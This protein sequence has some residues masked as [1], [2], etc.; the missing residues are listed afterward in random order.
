MPATE[1]YFDFTVGAPSGTSMTFLQD[2][3]TVIVSSALYY[4]NSNDPDH[5]AFEFSTPTLSTNEFGIGALNT[6]G[7]VDQGFDA[8][9]MYEM[10]TFSFAENVRITSIKLIPLPTR[11]NLTAQD[12]QFVIFNQDLLINQNSR[13]FIDPTDFINSVSVFG[14]YVGFGAVNQLDSFSLAGITVEAIGGLNA[15]ADNYAVKTSDAPVTLDVLANDD[16]GQRITAIDTT[17][18]LGSV[19]LAADGLTLVYSAGSAFDALAKGVQAT[20]TFTYTVLGFDGTS[21]TQTV[22]LT[23]TG[24]PNVIN[25]TAANNLL[26]G[27]ATRD[28][29]TG[30]AGNDTID[31]MGGNDDI[32]GRWGKD[33]LHGND[34]D[35]HVYG[36]GS[37]DYVYGDAGN[38]TVSGGAGNDRLH[39]GD[40]NDSIDGSIGSDRLYGDA[41]NDVLTGSAMAN[42]LSGGAGIDTMSGGAG[43]D[44]YYVDNA[45]DQVIELALG[46]MD[47]VHARA[48]FTLASYVENLII[49]GTTAVNGTGNAAANR[50][51]GNSANNVL[52]GLGGNDRLIGGLGNDRLVGGAGRDNVT[53]GAGFDAF[54]FAESGNANF[55]NVTDFNTAFDTIQLSSDVFGLAI[56]AIDASEFGLG[57][58]AT[59]ATQHLVYDRA[60]GDLYFDADGNGAGARQLIASF[61][62]GTVLHFD[63]I[64]TY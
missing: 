54:V 6:Y 61:V 55:D 52:S 4:G 2:G 21:Q 34:G 27:T 26:T 60:H 32:F 36:G 30:L 47:V 19:S 53:G 10:V 1:I 8:H 22:T 14:N 63:D 43:A 42:I 50:L 48:D 35:D 39:G 15:V 45:A 25:G 7:D 38:D 37:D 49:D 64:F 18:L 29:I 13:Q 56:G 16:N 17:S 9:G 12:T 40:G 44:I 3:M 11:Y 41:G 58:K 59:T 28:V 31:G 62:D 46:G 51:V 20:D 5:I 57:T 24:D 33:V 23:V